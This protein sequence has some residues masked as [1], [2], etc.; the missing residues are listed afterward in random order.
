MKALLNDEKTYKKEKKQPFKKIERE[1]NARLLTLKN[2]GKLNGRTYKKLYSTDG[3]PPT[4]RGLVKHHK[5]D[6]PLRPIITSIGSALYHTSKILTDILS[7]LQN[8][9]GLVVENS[10]EFVRE[11]SG[12]EIS[13]TK[14]GIVRCFL[15]VHRNT[16]T[17]RL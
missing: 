15:P 10:K 3:L 13:A 16:S 8:K 12:I 6:N 5:P 1:L 9:N 14:Y 2:Q 4:I 17:Q 7:P 11:I